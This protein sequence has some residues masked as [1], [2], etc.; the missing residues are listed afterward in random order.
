[1][2]ETQTKY[3]LEKRIISVNL[4]VYFCIAMVLFH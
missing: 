3:Y 4:P 2:H 1:L